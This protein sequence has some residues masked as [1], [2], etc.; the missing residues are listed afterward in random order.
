MS[1]TASPTRIAPAA[2]ELQAAS[3]N[4]ENHRVYG[5]LLS[6]YIAFCNRVGFEDGVG[7]WGGSQVVGPDGDV[8]AAGKQFEE[9]L[10]VARIDENEIRRARRFSRHVLDEDMRIVEQELK[11]IREEREDARGPGS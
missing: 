8:V 7:F 10:V 6:T 1:L 4:T 5:R 2:K 9:D 11:R 3:V